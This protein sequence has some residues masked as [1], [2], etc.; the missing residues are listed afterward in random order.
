MFRGAECGVGRMWCLWKVENKDD[1][2]AERRRRVFVA[3]VT[4]FVMVLDIIH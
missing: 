2:V 4:D 3:N 1:A